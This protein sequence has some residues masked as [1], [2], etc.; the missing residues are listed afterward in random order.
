MRIIYK[1]LFKGEQD[2]YELKSYVN[3][4][5]DASIYYYGAT[6]GDI[7]NSIALNIDAKVLNKNDIKIK[8]FS[9]DKIIDSQNGKQTNLNMLKVKGGIC[10]LKDD[11]EFRDLLVKTSHPADGRIFNIIF[12][13]P[14]IKQGR[15]TS[16]LRMAGKLSNP[17]IIGDFH[18]IETDIPFLDTTMKNIEF[19]FKDK[20]LEIKSKGEVLGNDVN[21][22]AILRNKL[23]KP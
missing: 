14:N 6:V 15:F 13:K 18:I 23:T 1:A 11:I 16:D 8:E 10:L 17:R 4:A 20:Y 19:V 7:E 3:M 5:K 12:G 9:Y 21:A 22:E 2:D